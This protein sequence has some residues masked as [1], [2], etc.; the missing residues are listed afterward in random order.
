MA[1]AMM[2]S[3]AS[4]ATIDAVNFENPDVLLQELLP[5]SLKAKLK[6]LEGPGQIG[7]FS[8]LV[9]HG[10]QNS[11]AVLD[12]GIVLSSG[13][14]S[15][16]PNRNSS[17]SFG[18]NTGG[19]GDSLID[20]L[21][22]LTANSSTDA[23]SIRFSFTAPDNVN[24]MVARF[25]YASEEYPDFAG[26]AFADG[27][28]AAR[29]ETIAGQKKDTN[30]AIFPNGKPVSLISQAS[31]LNFMANGSLTDPKVPVVADLEF[32]GISRIFELRLPVTANAQEDFSLIIA[33]TG[34]HFY[35]SAVFISAFRFFNDPDFDFSVATVRAE[36]NPLYI[37]F[38][39]P[40]PSPTPPSALAS[41]PLPG[42]AW[43]FGSGLLG[44]IIGKVRKIT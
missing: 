24:G 23:A 15:G 43:L 9:L 27:F 37:P 5:S 14:L 26:T 29:K 36:D 41:V 21:P 18:S 4:A 42:S 11:Q 6:Q 31:N 20:T 8:N 35:D 17:A 40:A 25:V 12:R 10:E 34:D 32:N 7:V 30:Y 19:A 16:L 33:D 3:T 38:S 28:V 1:L 13:Y 22:T 44:L 39:S 2:A